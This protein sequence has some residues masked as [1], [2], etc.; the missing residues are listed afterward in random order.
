MF[1]EDQQEKFVIPV[2][3][4][5]TDVHERIIH[6]KFISL[7]D[8]M[9]ETIRKII[10]AADKYLGYNWIYN[11]TPKFAEE[12]LI[13]NMKFN[14]N[15]SSLAIDTGYSFYH[16]PREKYLP[17]DLIKI[18]VPEWVNNINSKDMINP[19]KE[20]VLSAIPKKFGVISDYLIRRLEDESSNEIE[21]FFNCKVGII[22]I[23]KPIDRFNVP[24]ILTV[25][26][27]SYWVIREFNRRI[28]RNP[29][30]KDL[31]E[32]KKTNQ[33][34][35]T[36]NISEVDINCPSALYIEIAL[37]TADN[38]VCIVEKN[39]NLSVLADSGRSKWTSTLEEGLEW[40][41]DVDLKNS[42]IN[43]RSVIARC[44]NLELNIKEEFINEIQLV[45]IALEHT[46]LNTGIYGFCSVGLNS[47][48]I[49]KLIAQS[50]D[51]QLRC[52][53]LPLQFIEDEYFKRSSDDLKWHP[54]ARLRLFSVLS[55]YKNIRLENDDSI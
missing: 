19:S 45:G 52:K 6:K 21:G 46:H 25:I 15:Y 32:L 11:E 38:T 53:F 48:D 51:F 35:L 37:L 34:Q 26:P 13:Y 1:Y 9:E 54:T 5:D 42:S 3:I 2:R 22:K 44:L 24:M 16:S 36:Q 31:Q 41:K 20:E 23:E 18:K 28:L 12:S 40:H 27:L 43:M 8:D 55:W 49:K 33:L 4:D 47:G 7:E 14:R 17:N 10:S 50:E 39:P 29:D 30:D